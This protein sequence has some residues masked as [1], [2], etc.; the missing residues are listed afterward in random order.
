MNLLFWRK[1][2]KP[3]EIICKPETWKLTLYFK[4]GK[5]RTFYT[6]EPGM[7]QE[8]RAVVDWVKRAENR[9][10]NIGHDEG[11]ILLMLD[12]LEYVELNT[13]GVR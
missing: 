8:F 4:G 5:E 3:T 1:H 13:K 10:F 9:Y 11:D 12:A 2:K 6:V 7:K